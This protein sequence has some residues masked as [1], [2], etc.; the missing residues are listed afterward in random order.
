MKKTVRIILTVVIVLAALYFLPFITVEKTDDSGRTWRVP[1]L[2]SFVS[3]DGSQLTYSSIRSGYAM[4][5]DAANAVHSYEESKCYGTTYYYDE[6]NDVSFSGYTVKSGFPSS[7]V[8]LQYTAGN[9]CAG[10]TTNDEIAWPFG[11]IDD[12]DVNTTPEEAMEKDWFV[13]QDDKALDPVIWNEFSNHVKQGVYSYVRTMIYENGKLVKIVDIQNMETGYQQAQTAAEA[14]ARASAEAAGEI[15]D[16]GSLIRV[17]IRT[18]EGT[19]TKDYI[20]ISDLEE[21]DGSKPVNVYQKNDDQAE[22][23]LL[24]TVRS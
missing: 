13:I 18:E 20:R 2:S 7:S 22:A 1:F 9:A 3:D 11:S 10:W 5:K 23:T 8:S 14:E 19:E 24:F 4:G 6:D 17:W 12:V 21:A 16:S 15:D